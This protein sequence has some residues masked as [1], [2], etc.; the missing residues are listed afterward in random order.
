MKKNRFSFPSLVDVQ[1]EILRLYEVVGV[2][3]GV[4]VDKDGK[5]PAHFVGV[6]SKSEWRGALQKVGI[7]EAK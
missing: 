3:T 7:G 6:R 2:P 5:I 1:R 4:L